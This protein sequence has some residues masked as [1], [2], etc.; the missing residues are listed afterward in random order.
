MKLL[1]NIE[2]RFNPDDETNTQ[3]KSFSRISSN[4]YFRSDSDELN[5][6]NEFIIITNLSNL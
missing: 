4:F 2:G 6:N 5:N 1:L 3:T